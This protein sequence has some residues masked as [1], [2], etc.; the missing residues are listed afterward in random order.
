MKEIPVLYCC[1][2]SDSSGEKTFI[3][4]GFDGTLYRL[5]E[6]KNPILQR[7]S[8][9]GYHEPQNRRKVNKTFFIFQRV[10]RK[11]QILDIAP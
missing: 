1:E 10:F 2:I 5:V 3:A 9:D 8:D 7:P 4:H 11:R 6:R